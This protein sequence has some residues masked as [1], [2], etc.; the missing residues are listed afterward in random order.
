MHRHSWRV[1]IAAAL[2]VAVGLFIL[3]FPVLLDQYD[4]WG[5][6]IDCGT[7]FAAD[8]AQAEAAEDSAAVEV[9]R[10]ALTMRR[11]WTIPLIAGGTLMLIVVLLRATLTPQQR[12]V[13]AQHDTG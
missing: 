10:S 7:G 3:R 4:Q 5:W 1:G 2:M 13:S 9:C 8:L 12:R 6:Q 11:I